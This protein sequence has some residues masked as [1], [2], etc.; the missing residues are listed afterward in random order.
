MDNH[1][2][3]DELEALFDSISSMG[4]GAAPAPA[5]PAPVE[6]PSK[7][8]VSAPT[9]G[10]VAD[11]DELQDLFDS[12][13]MGF[14]AAPAA[15]ASVAVEVAQES[16]SDDSAWAGQEGVYQRIGK[17]ARELHNALHE[18][19]Y[20]KLLENTAAAIPD[21]RD[22]LA[23]I[24]NLTEQAANKV[25][26]ATDVAQ[27]LVDQ[28]LSSSDA[29]AKRWDAAFANQMDV[30]AFRQLAIETRGFLGKDLPSL[31]GNTSAQLVEIMMA[32]DFQDLTGQVIKKIVALAESL[33]S[34]LMKVLLEVMPENRKQSEEVNSLLNGPVV[35]SAGRTDVVVSQQQVDDL[36]D[37]LGF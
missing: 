7:P 13:S 33:E 29:L 5:A 30:A 1:N 15:P 6:A 4:V 17:M 28:M 32:Q 34:G 8:Q 25:L 35:T 14:S 16:A 20:D 22:R 31:A 12:I 3:S 2:D 23:Y 19:G 36:L 26:N 11:T 10:T 27:P 24:A 18:M 37:T 21:A 9:G